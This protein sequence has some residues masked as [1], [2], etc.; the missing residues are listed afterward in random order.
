MHSLNFTQRVNY[1]RVAVNRFVP[2]PSTRAD[3]LRYCSV[4]MCRVQWC[5]HKHFARTAS[6]E[7]RGFSGLQASGTGL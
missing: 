3:G 7:S 5:W 1:Q 6:L 2:R 4:T